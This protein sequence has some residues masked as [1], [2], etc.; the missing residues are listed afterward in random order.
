MPPPLKHDFLNPTLLSAQTLDQ[1]FTMRK[2]NQIV[3]GSV[4]HLHPLPPNLIRDLLQLEH[5]LLVKDHSYGLAYEASAGE[6][7]GVAT[8]EQFLRRES[9]AVCGEFVGFVGR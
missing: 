2:R 1:H 3:S 6:A 4:H 8:L 7:F 9:I 5:A